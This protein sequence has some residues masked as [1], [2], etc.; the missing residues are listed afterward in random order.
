[1]LDVDRLLSRADPRGEGVADQRLLASGTP[2]RWSGWASRRSWSPTGR[3][4]CAPSPGRAT[5]SGS[6]GRFRRPASPPLRRS[7]RPG[8]PSCCAGSAQALAQEARACNLSVILGPGINMKRSPLCGRNFEYF[9]E[10]P[11][12]AGEL[13]VGIVDGIQSRGVGTSVKHYAANNQETDRLRV[14]AQVDE[15]T[16]RE[17]YLPAFER[18]V[19]AV[20]AV[21]RDVLL[22]QG[23]RP[24]R[25]GEHLAAHHRAAG[26]VRLRGAGRLGLGCGL[27]PRAGA[28]GR[29]G[30]GDA[31]GA[32]AQPGGRS[33][34]RSRPARCRPRCSTPGSARCWSWSPRACRCS[35]W[36]SRSTPD[37]HH[38][39]AREAAA[40]SV[41]LLKNDG[42]LPLAADAQDRGHRRVRP[43]AAV[44]GRRVVPGQPDPGRRAAG[45]AARGLRR[46]A[47]RGRLRHRRHRRRRRPC[48]PRPSRWPVRPTP[49]SW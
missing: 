29:A 39:L 23:Q 12:L 18:V 3:T 37:A 16:L 26:G 5:T 47:V 42:L 10:D 33:S 21:D 34:R 49:S 46:R 28:A 9:S 15:R 45:R 27:P 6:A 38:A 31:A 40:E 43:H 35:S 20:A 1:M 44:P 4:G 32:G 19:K 8:T 7:P 22:Q 25:V 36:T 48:S 14:D 2:R 11:F 24:V 13:A 41:V 17:I 30:P